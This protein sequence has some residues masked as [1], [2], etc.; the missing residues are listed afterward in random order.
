MASLNNI[1][2][3]FDIEPIVKLFCKE[4]RCEH[5]MAREHGLA[6]CEL[7]ALTME[8]GGVCGRMVIPDKEFEHA[9]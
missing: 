8:D 1:S 7:K 4:T 2:V 3:V 9:K 5:N 6:L